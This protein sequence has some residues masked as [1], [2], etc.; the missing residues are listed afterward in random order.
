[1]KS[2]KESN[3][4]ENEKNSKKSSFDILK[5]KSPEFKNFYLSN[6]EEKIKNQNYPLKE[7]NPHDVINSIEYELIGIP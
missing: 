5:W 3:R 7:D 6:R 1:M 4:E 2:A